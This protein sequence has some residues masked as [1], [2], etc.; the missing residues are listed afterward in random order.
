MS[1]YEGG[2]WGPD[3]EWE[4]MQRNA[5]RGPRLILWLAFLAIAGATAWLLRICGGKFIWPEEVEEGRCDA[6]APILPTEPEKAPLKTREEIA[7][8]AV[9]M[10]DPRWERLT[11]Y[12][13]EVW[14]ANINTSL[15]SYQTALCA[16]RLADAAFGPAQEEK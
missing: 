9:C 12:Q 6:A 11:S 2:G 5:E 15:H 16:L 7:A 1:H 13:Q 4:E 14:L 8:L 3:P 10:Q